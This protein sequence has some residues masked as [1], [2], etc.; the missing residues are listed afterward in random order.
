[1]PIELWYITS[2]T[3]ND[4]ARPLIDMLGDIRAVKNGVFSATM[5]VNAGMIVEYVVMENEGYAD[6]ARTKAS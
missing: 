5:K 2:M 1:M 3:N 6:S 4:N